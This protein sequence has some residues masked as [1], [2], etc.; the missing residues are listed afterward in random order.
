M[1]TR[2]GR[3]T[4]P[5]NSGTA[6]G[7][8]AIIPA[9]NKNQL[10]PNKTFSLWNKF[11]H[12]HGWA[13]GFGAIYQDES[14]TALGSTVKL[15]AFWRFDGAI[16]YTFVG[17]ITRLALNIENILNRKYYPIADGN[18]NISPGAPVNARLTLS[19]AF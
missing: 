6:T 14:F 5:T 10:A 19:T 17:S 2:Y 8:A 4:K 12:G 1:A 7:L 16:Y 15:P 3:T 13:S 11:T 9:G 18:N